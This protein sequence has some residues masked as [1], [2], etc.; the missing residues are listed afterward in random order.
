MAG[1]H[2]PEC[3]RQDGGCVTERRPFDVAAYVRRSTSGRCFV[4]EFLRGAPNYEHI[5]VA[6]T[7]DAIAFLNRYPTLFGYVI[8]AP[9]RHV[10]QVT[11]DFAEAEYLELQRF[12]YRIAEGIRRVLSP[13]RIYVLSLGSQAANAHVHWHV[14]PLPSGVPLE[15]QQ[16]FALMHENGAIE[17]N[18]AELRN[19]AAQVA[20]AVASLE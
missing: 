16:Y 3:V 19:Y 11:G 1:A 9:K 6:E 13:E 12:I 8:V 5:T 10:E 14:A 17:C 7:E 20:H 2:A 15:K 18:D 4:C